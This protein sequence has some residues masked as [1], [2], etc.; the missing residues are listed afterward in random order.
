MKYD[1][2]TKALIML[3]TVEGYKARRKKFDQ[4]ERPAELYDDYSIADRMIED[5]D[6]FGV[7]VMTILDDDYPPQLKSIYDPPLTLYY[8]GDKNLLSQ[9]NLL[10]VVGTRRV[11]AYGKNIMQNFLPVFIDSG[12]VIVSGL[13]R[14]VD[15]IGHRFCVD[16]GKATIG[17]VAN[18]LDICYP[19]ENERLQ[20]Q[21]SKVG[22]LVS[23]YPIKTKP[24]QFH[25][26][27]RNR[28]ISGLSKG[29]FIPEAGDKSG[30]LIT[31]DDAVEQ[32]REL[33]V[34]P[35]SIFSTASVGCNKKIK[36]LQA[37]IALTPEDVLETLGYDA[38]KT[39][40]EVVQLSLEEQ[41]LINLM[42]SEKIHLYALME[43]SGLN[44]AA[45][46]SE[47]S[48]LEIM[49]VIR[50]QQGNYYEVIPSM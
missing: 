7:R 4:V 14:G 33:F 48:R 26:P 16:K 30:S 11:T 24:L 20:E 35:G 2:D 9:E 8:I 27:E 25:F 13:A 6:K 41:A 18:G 50:K 17:V 10:G 32:G 45:L 31:A 34:V 37:T 40:K 46:S 39:E 21:V 5:M 19:P 1:N 22:V 42:G 44:I 15:S 43:K 36:E 28:I 38:K 49:G 47:L 29:I 3:S 23:E 12:L